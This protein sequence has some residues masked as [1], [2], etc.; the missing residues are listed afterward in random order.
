MMGLALNVT[1][2]KS[3]LARHI[4]DPFALLRQINL[5]NSS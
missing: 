4:T 5:W 2:V 3:W 1:G